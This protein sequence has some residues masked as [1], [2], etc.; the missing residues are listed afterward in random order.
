MHIYHAVLQFDPCIVV[1]QVTSR[2]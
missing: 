1:L 2:K